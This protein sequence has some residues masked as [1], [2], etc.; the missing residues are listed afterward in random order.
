MSKKSRIIFLS[1]GID[2]VGFR[3]FYHYRI[4]RRRNLRSIKGKIRL[5]SR[6]EILFDKMSEIFQGWN[7]YAKWA[8]TYKL[9]KNIA[10]ELCMQSIKN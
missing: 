10:R 2:F 4:L 8:D 7:A 6:G 9:R 5:F 3:N 1:Q